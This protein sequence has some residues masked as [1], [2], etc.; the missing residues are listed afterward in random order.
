MEP[1]RV[2]RRLLKPTAQVPTTFWEVF[3][4][5]LHDGD[6]LGVWFVLR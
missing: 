1:G 3:F 5:A 6:A 2:L 4:A